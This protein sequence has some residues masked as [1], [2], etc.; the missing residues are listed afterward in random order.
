MRVSLTTIFAFINFVSSF[1]KPVAATRGH[2]RSDP[3]SVGS[4]EFIA[5]WQASGIGS[6]PQCQS[7]CK[8]MGK[9]QNCFQDNR[10][11]VITRHAMDSVSGDGRSDVDGSRRVSGD[12]VDSARTNTQ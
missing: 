2:G 5:Y 6:F 10:P 9:W 3:D 11:F 8:K 12:A 4:R 1:E 7:T